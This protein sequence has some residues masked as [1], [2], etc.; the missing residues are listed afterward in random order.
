MTE[1]EQKVTVWKDGTWTVSVQGDAYYNEDDPDWLVSIPVK[2]IL[3]V[4]GHPEP[5]RTAVIAG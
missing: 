2:L 4:A 1:I 3:E 5:T